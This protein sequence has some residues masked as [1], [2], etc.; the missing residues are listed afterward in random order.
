MDRKSPRNFGSLKL[1]KRHHKSLLTSPLCREARGSANR[2]T[3]TLPPDFGSTGSL[4]VA[5]TAKIAGLHYSRRRSGRRARGPV[6]PLEGG[7]ESP[8][9]SI[10]ID[11]SKVIVKKNIDRLAKEGEGSFPHG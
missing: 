3:R 6:G 11:Y 8:Q 9:P 10:M 1:E 4:P 2:S 5:I 7:S